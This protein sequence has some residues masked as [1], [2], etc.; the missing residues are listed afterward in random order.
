MSLFLV[1]R[2]GPSGLF[3][4]SRL[5]R[6]LLLVFHLSSGDVKPVA[7]HCPVI[8]LSR[9]EIACDQ[10]TTMRACV[11]M[12]FLFLDCSIPDAKPV[13]AHCP[14]I[15]LEGSSMVCCV[16]AHGAAPE[17]APQIL[18]DVWELWREGTSLETCQKGLA[19]GCSK[20][21]FYGIRK[22]R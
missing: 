6:V 22:R 18:A 9:R 14:V 15:N 21:F 10:A 12:L 11:L 8:N 3:L 16:G 1:V 4:A 7:A 2:N 17:M 19:R 13:A 5:L 20:M